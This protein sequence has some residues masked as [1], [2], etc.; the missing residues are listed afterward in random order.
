MVITV[1]A[2]TLERSLRVERR[3]W[4][5]NRRRFT[6]RDELRVNYLGMM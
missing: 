3:W 5:C 6:N 4:K 2:T 1:A